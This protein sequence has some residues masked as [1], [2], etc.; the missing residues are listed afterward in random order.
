[1][2]SKEQQNMGNDEL[3][4]E[5][6][7][8]NTESDAKED[9]IETADK[10]DGVL[11]ENTAEKRVR[12][13][14]APLI[15]AAF[16]FLAAL[17]FFCTWKCFFDTNINGT[18]EIE[19]VSSDNSE[20]VP[21]DLTF[22]GNKTVRFHS[23]GMVYVGRYDFSNDE[24]YGDVLNLYIPVYG[25]VQLF[26]FN[27]R[28]EGNFF[29]GRV[30]KLTDLSGMFL[31]PDD[32]SSKDDDVD[33]KKKITDSVDIDGTT[34]YRWDFSPAVEEYKLSKYKDFKKD[35]NIIGSW[36]YKNDEANYAYTMTFNDDGTFEQLAPELEIHGTYTV[37][38]GVCYTKFYLIS[39]V[40][41]EQ[42]FEYKSDGKTFGF[43]D[44]EFTKTND[45]YA[46]LS[47]SN[48]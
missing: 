35:K 16:I 2:V 21:F 14:R 22:C 36:L 11:N 39:G 32:S 12:H 17:L 26:K 6:T 25:Q 3:E 40:E 30:L 34:Y 7:E 28:F 45:K 46:Y 24:G 13:G 23:G 15:T 18:W 31:A 4:K 47:E 10:T 33:G 5:D 41:S 43:E 8:A 1:M 29:S 44:Y 19:I 37:K 27:Y 48:Q 9:D 42:E 20:K 38:D